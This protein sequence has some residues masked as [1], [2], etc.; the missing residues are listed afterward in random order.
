VALEIHPVTPERWADMVELFERRGVRGGRRNTP[1]Y[2]CW[3]MYW[4]D[5]TLA[6]GEPKKRAMAKLV[7]S[8][9]EPGLLAYDDGSPVGWIAIAR[10]AEYTAIVRSPQYR[11]REEGG[12][13]AVWSIVCF[14]IDKDARRQG[15]ASA[16]LDAAVAHAFAHGATSVE[17]YPHVGNAGDYMG[18]TELYSRAGFAHVRDAN[19]RA[20]VRLE[21]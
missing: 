12:G 6:H 20:I 11:P 5:R 9:R 8:G 16:L 2:G 14:T 15:V 3:C 17:A 4:R 19:K 21:R 1:A 18:N 7:R 13:A 10:R